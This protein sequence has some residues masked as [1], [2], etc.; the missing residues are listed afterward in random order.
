[1]GGIRDN[2]PPGADLALKSA[3]VVAKGTAK[4]TSHALIGKD[5]GMTKGSVMGDDSSSLCDTDGQDTHFDNLEQAENSA[6]R[7]NC[8]VKGLIA[9]AAAAGVT[10]LKLKNMTSMAVPLDEL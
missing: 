3:K 9:A 5:I 8:K 1:M 6:C 2:L 10:S 7:L 4:A